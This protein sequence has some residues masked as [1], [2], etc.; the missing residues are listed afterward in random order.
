MA[1]PGRQGVVMRRMPPGSSSTGRCYWARAVGRSAMRSSSR[2][3]PQPSGDRESR[4]CRPVRRSGRR[5]GRL[6][7]G[8]DAAAADVR[9]GQ[10]RDLPQATRPQAVQRQRRE[11]RRGRGSRQRRD[12]IIPPFRYDGGTYPGKNWDLKGQATWYFGC[13][14]AN[15][16]DVTPTR[17]SASRPGPTAP[18]RTSATGTRELDG[19][20]PGRPR[21]R[22][23]PR[24][25]EPR[26]ALTFEPGTQADVVHRALLRLARLEPRGQ[27][28]ERFVGR[29]RAA[30]RR[31]GSTRRSTPAND[32]GRFDLLLDGP[33]RATAVG[34]GGTTEHASR[35]D[36][37]TAHRLASARPNGRASPT[38]TRRSS[39]ATTAAAEPSSRRA[40]G[41][42]S[43]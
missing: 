26:P 25:R 12:D 43:P 1:G 28:C 38:T 16:P 34:N 20:D 24:A 14:P 22:V 37:G 17:P 31:S 36:A 3:R 11:H 39:A 15:V 10:G 18:T 2:C 7:L 42:A 32:P 27:V 33:A 5:N 29:R 41:R 9:G 8:R 40:R 21:Q 6:R 4:S 13:D 30:R 19:H 23:R 35:R